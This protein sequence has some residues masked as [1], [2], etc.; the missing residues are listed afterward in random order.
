MDNPPVPDASDRDQVRAAAAEDAVGRVERETTAL[1]HFSLNPVWSQEYCDRAVD[2]YTYPLLALLDQHGPL[3]LGEVAARLR[4]SK[5][6]ISRQIGRLRAAALVSNGPD[7]HDPRITIVSLTDRGARTAQ[8][9]RAARRIGLE[10]LLSS[11]RESDRQA[12]AALLELLNRDLN[13]R[14][15]HQPEPSGSTEQNDLPCDREPRA[16]V[17]ERMDPRPSSSPGAGGSRSCSRPCCSPQPASTSVAPAPITSPSR[18][19]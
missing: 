12:L 13:Q 6:A 2:R 3:R 11:W 16:A 4:L 17:I 18:A 1:L 19:R 9:I 14:F 8:R 15:H 5:P 10:D 7:P